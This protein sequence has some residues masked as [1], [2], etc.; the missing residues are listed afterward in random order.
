WRVGLT[1][2]KQSIPVSTLSI[3]PYAFIPMVAASP[4]A[5]RKAAT[6]P[7][8]SQMLLPASLVPSRPSVAPRRMA[9]HAPSAISQIG[10]DAAPTNTEA[11]TLRADVSLGR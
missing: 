2:L 10:D 3:P 1:F 11:M 5:S 6:V 9:S 4:A 8:G 7:S